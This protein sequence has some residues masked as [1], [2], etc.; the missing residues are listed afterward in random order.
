MLTMSCAEVRRELSAYHDEELSIGERIAIADHLENCPG[1][2]VEA[3]DLMAMRDALQAGHHSDQVAWGPMLAR[4]QSDVVTRLAAEERVAFATWARELVEDRRRVLTTVASMVV[5]CVLVVFGLCQLSRGTVEHP[6]SLQALLEHEQKVW[7]ARAEMPV[8]LP[9][10]NPDT[11]MPVAMVNQGDDDESLSAFSALVTS[12]GQL[13][14]LELLEE[15]SETPAA[16]H[17]SHKQLESDL[18]AA[19]AT[20]S[21][22]PARQAAGGPVALNVVWVVTHRT[23]RPNAHARVEVT[24]TFR[25]KRSDRV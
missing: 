21:F 6:D 5:A 15:Q 17:A 12:D 4:L 2:S 8:M 25:Y 1:C 24:S 16:K 18:M 11:M 19:A 14:Q 22:Q 10:V 3:D 23:V 13:A 9:R 20:A 7:A